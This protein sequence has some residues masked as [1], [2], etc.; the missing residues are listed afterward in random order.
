MSFRFA[1]RGYHLLHVCI[2]S[3][4]RKW[5][6]STS[7]LPMTRSCHTF[8]VIKLIAYHHDIANQWASILTKCL[9]SRET[10]DN[11]MQ[12]YSVFDV[13]TTGGVSSPVSVNLMFRCEHFLYAK[14]SRA[15]HIFFVFMSKPQTCAVCRTLLV[16]FAIP[17]FITTSTG[18]IIC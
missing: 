12:C 10:Y 11:F 2:W 13:L 7:K 6:M 1:R 15:P 9:P 17:L 14:I 3:F 18:T 4:D 16:K 8:P 5:D